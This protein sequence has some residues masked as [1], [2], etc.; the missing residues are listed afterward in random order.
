MTDNRIARTYKQLME[1]RDLVI[2]PSKTYNDYKSLGEDKTST[3]VRMDRSRVVIECGYSLLAKLFFS[4]QNIKKIQN[5]LR[6]KVWQDLKIKVSEQD[7]AELV[8]IM[9]SIF[10]TYSKDLEHS[11]PKQIAD[12]NERVVA[13]AYPSMRTNIIRYY[14]YMDKSNS[15]LSIMEREKNVSST[16]TKILRTG[17]ALGFGDDNG[18]TRF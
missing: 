1:E 2:D 12:L 3:G 15:T 17:D 6:Y 10:L 5:A 18:F 4:D 16:G 8:I 11:Y 7:L 9:R 14:Q 13:A